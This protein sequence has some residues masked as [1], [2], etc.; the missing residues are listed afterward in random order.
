MTRRGEQARV[1]VWETA[2]NCLKKNKNG[3]AS[4]AAVTAALRIAVFLPLLL[5]VDFGGKLPMWMGYVLA[6][7]VYIFGV[8][9]MRFWGREKVRRMFCSQ[10]SNHCYE[11]VPD[12]SS[13]KIR[14]CSV[15]SL[16]MWKFLT[17]PSAR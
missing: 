17:S 10:H 5:C 16:R 1:S 6:A 7:A 13:R 3:I 14:N 9:P 4:V 15:P 8:I 12:R 2:W 11:N